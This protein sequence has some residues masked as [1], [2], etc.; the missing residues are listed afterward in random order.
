MP[1]FIERDAACYF[2]ARLYFA[3][4]MITQVDNF[5]FTS[6]HDAD[7]MIPAASVL[8]HLSFAFYTPQAPREC[9]NT[10]IYE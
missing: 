8:R 7:A 6:R 2:H 4:T 10:T 1:G 5:I 9:R 3:H